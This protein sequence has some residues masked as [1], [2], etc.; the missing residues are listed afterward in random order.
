MGVNGGEKGGKEGFGE[1]SFDFNCIRSRFKS[2]VGNFTLKMQKIFAIGFRHLK[3]F[4]FVFDKFDANGSA[5]GL[6]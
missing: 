1:I 3:I 5:F 2:R 4:P 6:R